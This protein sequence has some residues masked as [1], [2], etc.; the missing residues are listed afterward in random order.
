MLCIDVCMLC[1]LC[2]HAKEIFWLELFS[3][4]GIEN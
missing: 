1:M 2:M 4:T 3:E